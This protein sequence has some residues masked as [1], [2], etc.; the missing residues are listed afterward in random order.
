MS[1][2][3]TASAR[4]RKPSHSCLSY[5]SLLRQSAFF[6]PAT[7]G[8]HGKAFESVWLEV[9]SLLH[10]GAE[11]VGELMEHVVC[12]MMVRLEVSCPAQKQ[13]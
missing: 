4:L 12:A 8:G 13:T 2:H 7:H 9:R 10:C 3:A 6:R 11:H 1:N 5:P